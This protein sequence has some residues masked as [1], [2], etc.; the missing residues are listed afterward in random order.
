MTDK[1]AELLCV[2]IIWD[3][4]VIPLPHKDLGF[5]QLHVPPEPGRPF[6]R[7][8]LALQAAWEQITTPTTAGMLLLDGDVMIDPHDLAVMHKA[9]NSDP[10]RVWT[11]PVKL[12]RAAMR[13]AGGGWIWSH[14]TAFPRDQGQNDDWDEHELFRFSFCFTYLPRR[15]LEAA[16]RSG[17]KTW[18]YP[19]CDMRMH[20]LAARLDIPVQI[21]RD[22]CTP[23]HGNY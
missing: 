1:P 22:G 16:V 17:L 11:A 12:W 15:L 3:R 10:A 13:E 9:I 20:Q 8:G 5:H 23:K 14:M 19:H 21:V 2:R 7:K 18:A 4:Q 6:G